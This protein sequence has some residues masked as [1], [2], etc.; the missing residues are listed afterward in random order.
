MDITTVVKKQYEF[1]D[2]HWNH[3]ES[4]FHTHVGLK[5]VN[6]WRDRKL[7]EYHLNFRD[8]LFS[9]SGIM[10]NRMIRTRDGAPF[11]QLGGSFIT[12]HDVI[13]STEIINDPEF[14]GFLIASL[15]EVG[16][17][18]PYY[19]EVDLGEFPYK[20][21][22]KNLQQLKHKNQEVY[23]S[24]VRYIPKV[25]QRKSSLLMNPTCYDGNALKM[26][27]G[28]YYY[29]LSNSL[30]K[31][32]HQV[33]RRALL[34][35][36]YT[37][38]DRKACWAS[39]HNAISGDLVDRVKLTLLAPWEW[40]DC[41]REMQDCEDEEEVYNRYKKEWDTMMELYEVLKLSTRRT[42]SYE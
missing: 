41:V 11:V 40:T 25:K 19:N 34:T 1:K 21:A 31:P 14:L 39:L 3:K 10:C 7:L 4:A 15:L 2:L 28:Q 24:L 5:R 8:R 23:S 35:D 26:V 36:S 6:Y 38:E 16:S 30:P 42:I 13:E 27:M 33:I 32:A 22:L 29:D 18:V 12:I 9:K 20:E 17:E 37:E